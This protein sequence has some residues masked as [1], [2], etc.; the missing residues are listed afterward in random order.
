MVAHAAK[1]IFPLSLAH[2]RFQFH[3]QRQCAILV[4][5]CDCVCVCVCMNPIVCVSDVISSPPLAF[6]GVSTDHGLVVACE[7]KVFVITD[8]ITTIGDLNMSVQQS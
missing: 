7:T 2:R 5:G 6:I 3:P 1:S 8:E 4:R